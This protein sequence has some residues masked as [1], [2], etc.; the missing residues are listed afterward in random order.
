MISTE[1][2]RKQLLN[3]DKYNILFAIL[4]KITTCDELT[5]VNYYYDSID[6]I[7]YEKGDTL[8]VRQKFGELSLEKKFNKR[9]SSNG[10]K[11]CDESYR[12]ISELPILIKSGGIEYHYIGN[13][14][15]IRKNFKV[16]NNLISLDTNYYYGKV[17]YEIEIESNEVKCVPG[18]INKI[19]NFEDNQIG[20][21]TRF[22]QKLKEMN[23]Q[24]ELLKE[25]L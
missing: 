6:F 16:D 15:T 11:I 4:N 17:D 23:V 5:Q 9:F 2:E 21:Y 14:V 8:R 3:E 19:I 20:K 22:I 24:Y 1:Y 7:L 18:F 25:N 10:V 12:T 13:M